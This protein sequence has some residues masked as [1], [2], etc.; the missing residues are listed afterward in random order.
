MHNKFNN[1]MG[2]PIHTR[3]RVSFAAHARLSLYLSKHHIVGNHMSWLNFGKDT[4]ADHLTRF[5]IKK[6]TAI[7]NAAALPK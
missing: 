1:C 7:P 2:E 3:S 5:S 4:I 6:N